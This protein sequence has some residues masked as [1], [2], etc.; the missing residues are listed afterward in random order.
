METL[1]HE[2]N[3]SVCYNI[4]LHAHNKTKNI[5]HYFLTEFKTY[6]LSYSILQILIQ[7]VV[8]QIVN[9]NSVPKILSSK[10]LTIVLQGMTLSYFHIALLIIPTIIEVVLLPSNVTF[11]ADDVGSLTLS[12]EVLSVLLALKL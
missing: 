6:H 2:H 10:K 12:L 4:M 9:R 11:S 7:Y 5:F 3:L 8:F 1:L